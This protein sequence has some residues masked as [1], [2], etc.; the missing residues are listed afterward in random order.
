MTG[1]IS[2]RQLIIHPLPLLL[3][4]PFERRN[5]FGEIFQSQNTCNGSFNDALL[6]NRWGE[7]TEVFDKTRNCF[8]VLLL[9]KHIKGVQGL[10]RILK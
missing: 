10:D 3:I 1:F 4:C 2:V 8:W 7:R 5:Q 6:T 9:E